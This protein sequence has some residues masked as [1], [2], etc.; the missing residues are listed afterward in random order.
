MKTLSAEPVTVVVQLIVK[1]LICRLFAVYHA[2]APSRVCLGLMLLFPVPFK[3]SA[4]AARPGDYLP[5]LP[6]FNVGSST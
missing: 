3:L 5:L 6:A 4:Q 1:N 2:E